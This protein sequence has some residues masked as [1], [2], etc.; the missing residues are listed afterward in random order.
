MM[1][2]WRL[3][4][5]YAGLEHLAP[6]LTLIVGERDLAAPPAQA[7]ETAAQ[8]G[9]ARV[10]VV[11]DVGHLA[12]EEAPERVAALIEAAADRAG[13]SRTAEDGG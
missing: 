10:E 7:H 8:A 2:Q 1:S 9:G 13:I 11:E 4:A 5:V 6:A 12:H 3:D